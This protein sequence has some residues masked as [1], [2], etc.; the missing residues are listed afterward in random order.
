MKEQFVPAERRDI[1]SSNADNEF[2]R[3]FDKE[4][5]NFNIHSRSAKFNMASTF[6]I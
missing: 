4:N 6:K 5:I 1:A 2:N 3:A